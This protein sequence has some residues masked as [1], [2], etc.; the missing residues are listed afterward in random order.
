MTELGEYNYLLFNFD[1]ESDDDIYLVHVHEHNSMD[2]ENEH[3]Q[4]LEDEKDMY[5]F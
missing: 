2:E 4:A 5:I 3:N 1:D